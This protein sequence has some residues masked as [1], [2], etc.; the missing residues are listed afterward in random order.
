MRF[1]E[2]LILLLIDKEHG[3]LVPV[4]D[5]SLRSALAGSVLMDLALED[6]VDN[7][8]EHLFL[9][10][11][12]P[13]GD[14]LLD[15]WLRVIASAPERRLLGGA[16]RGAC[17]GLRHSRQGGRTPGGSPHSGTGGR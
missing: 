14:D 15:P 13:V 12:T 6:R 2:E 1:A 8:M 7:D 5:G 11:P 3:D 16:A 10:D 4:P 9:V 17:R